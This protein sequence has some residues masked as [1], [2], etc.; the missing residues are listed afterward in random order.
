VYQLDRFVAIIRPREAF[1]GWVRGLPDFEDMNLSLEQVRA[2]STALVIPQFDD[3]DE[4]VAFVYRLW[5]EVFMAELD[6]WTEEKAL[7]PQG[8]TIEMFMEWF[9]VEIHTSVAEIEE[10]DARV[11]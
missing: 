10:S 1:L 3:D 4:A 11:H 7:W 5:E 2:D 8:R 9:E 6:A